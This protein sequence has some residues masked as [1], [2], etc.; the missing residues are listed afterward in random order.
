MADEK[1]PIIEYE[2]NREKIRGRAI[3]LARGVSMVSMVMT[4]FTTLQ[5]SRDAW[6]FSAIFGSI[7]ATAACWGAAMGWQSRR[8]DAYLMILAGIL[9]TGIGGFMVVDRFFP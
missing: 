4:F 3:T 8:R 6:I 9:G 7:C 1:P 2:N 5:M